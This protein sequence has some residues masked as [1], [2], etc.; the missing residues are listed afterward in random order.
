MK[1]V[2]SIAVFIALA[3]MMALSFAPAEWVGARDGFSSLAG[4]ATAVALAAVGVVGG[5]VWLK[6]RRRRDD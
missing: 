2:F 3:A 1:S 5:W 4:V 6:D